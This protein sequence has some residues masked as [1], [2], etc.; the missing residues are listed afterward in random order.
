MI[1]P[2]CGTEN[3]AGDAFCG[4][5]GAYLEFAAEETGEEG[6]EAGAGEGVVEAGV[7][8]AGA[9]PP[10]GVPGA[11]PPEQSAGTPAVTAASAAALTAPPAPV[12]AAPSEPGA[13]PTCAACGRVNPAGRRF[14]IS[15]GELLPV[16]HK[17]AG[18][19]PAG[20]P[21]KPAWDFPMP[22][23][24][25]TA[26]APE[27]HQAEPASE[28]RSRLLLG[29]IVVVVVALVAVGGIF[30]LGGGLGG[31]TAGASQSA[32]PSGAMATGEPSPGESAAAGSPGSSAEP[33]G[34]PSPEA[35]PAATIPPGPSV[36][37]KI[38]GAKA[39]SQL[40]ASAAPKYLFD[41][42]P[43]TAWRSAAAK[44]EGSWVE[45]TF[46]PAAITEIWIQSGWQKDDPN[47]LGN[48][49]P[50][51]VTV[52]FDGA[53]PVPVELQDVQTIKPA[54]TWLKVP[55][56]AEL[57]IARATKIRITVID[58]YKAQKTSAKGTP[59]KS[60]AISEIRLFGI[61]VTP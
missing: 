9:V 35:T 54:R 44:F 14:C 45:V 36:G 15:C 52:S 7:A 30:L 57:G 27:A 18:T 29:G 37:V 13:G 42:S 38:T 4:G 25:V 16:A 22:T 51:D 50:H 31:G 12:A 48:H 33:S 40:A 53:I 60:A 56:P 19:A 1:C 20:A 32:S 6:V 28:G 24:P 2:K 34:S 8:T 3:A 59:T 23:V 10:P 61:P 55:I 47:L 26:A 46:A 41:G 5:C 43:V 21:G 17:A 49:R 58:V 39:S 11:L